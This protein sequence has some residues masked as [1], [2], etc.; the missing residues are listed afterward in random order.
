MEQEFDK[1]IFNEFFLIEFTKELIRNY[2]KIYPFEPKVEE[3]KKPE[4]EGIKE[5]VRKEIEKEE[6]KKELVRKKGVLSLGKLNLEELRKPP[7]KIPFK[8]PLRRKHIF[9]RRVSP[10]KLLRIPEPTLP[11]QFQY[12][13]PAPGTEEIDLSKLN[14]FVKDPLVK[15]IECP[16]PGEHIF[17]YGAMGRK[18]TGII[19]SK[20]E[21]DDIINRFSKA[22]KIPVIKGI[23]KVV[24]GRLI[25]SAI[26][27]DVIGSKF[28]I[29]KMVLS[30]K[31][32]PPF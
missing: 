16:G 29:R 13:T 14:P 11:P 28:I 4:K 32:L 6:K 3:E 27:S 25:L 18:P 2:S 7:K 19:L 22:T 12:L 31:N 21:I 26:I 5:K 8:T 23:Y 20:E 24:V 1:K 9:P 17:V 10:M 15:I 30:S